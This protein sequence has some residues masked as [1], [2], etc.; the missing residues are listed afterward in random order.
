MVGWLLFAGALGAAAGAATNH[1]FHLRRFLRLRRR[2]AKVRLTASVPHDVVIPDEQT[3]EYLERVETACNKLLQDEQRLKAILDSLS[4]GLA[5]LDRR[6]T[7]ALNN[8]AFVSMFRADVGQSIP[9][10]CLVPE[11]REEFFRCC[12]TALR[13]ERV[14]TAELHLTTTPPRDLFTTFTPYGDEQLAR[15]VIVTAL[16]VTQRKRVESMRSEFVANVSHELR[17]P[18]AAIRGYV[19]TC[20]EAEQDGQPPP[21]R[22]FLPIIQQHAVRLSALIED[23]LILSRIE[24]RAAQLKITPMSIAPVVE[25]AL[26][27][28]ASTAERKRISLI[29][30]LPPLLPEVKADASSLER[31]LIN[32]VE[33]AVK[34][35]EDDS[36]VR[37]TARL[38]EEVLC[39]LVEDR[40]VG[41]PREDQA[42][43]FERFYRVDKARSRKA[44]GTGLGL[45][46]VKHLVQSMAG[47]VW[48][49][50]E[51][52]RGSTF[53]FTLPLAGA[54]EKVAAPMGS[55]P[56]RV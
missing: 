41:I 48:V 3:N 2:A 15:G 22:R 39:V 5:L 11:S 30:A 1:Y 24:S 49:D 53:F 26:S 40:G 50:S 56:A 43:I 45:S 37:L 8:P 44:G 31:V 32:L 25:Q 36:E 51:L 7:V 47:E 17:T 19:E 13:D 10:D 12:E 52:G 9:G 42:R 14:M 38:Q 54:P 23:L 18:L 20:I 46:I 34:Y 16:D 4:E 6:Q 27:T 33:N 28:V 35:S 29:N 21:Y 55:A